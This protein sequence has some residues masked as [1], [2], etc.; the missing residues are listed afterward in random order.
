MD[1]ASGDRVFEHSSV[2][3]FYLHVTNDQIDYSVVNST[4]EYTKESTDYIH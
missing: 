4:I 3:L 2:F 1:F